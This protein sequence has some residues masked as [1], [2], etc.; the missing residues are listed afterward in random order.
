ML[1]MELELEER[2]WEWDAYILH[3]LRHCSSCFAG[4]PNVVGV[5][6]DA[7]CSSHNA[8]VGQAGTKLVYVCFS[9]GM[10]RF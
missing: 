10:P 2:K 3:R 8:I 1:E 4:L 6:D 9:F 5:A 7:A